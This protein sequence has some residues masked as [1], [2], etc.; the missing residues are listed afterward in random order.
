LKRQLF[1][2]V[3][4]G[5]CAAFTHMSVV[6]LLVEVFG[7]P[8]AVS[9]IAAFCVAFC[10]SFNGHARFTFPQPPEARAEACRRFIIIA[11]TAFTLNQLSYT[12][13][14]TLF[15]PELYLPIL[16]VVLL[17]VAAFT[18]TMSRYWA[19][20]LRKQTAALRKQTA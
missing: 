10:V 19:F 14:L 3:A 5:C 8:A 6:V 1:F 15:G 7:W 2:F 9:N 13:A 16:F 18:F 20:A 17:C 4:V 12:Y 11:L